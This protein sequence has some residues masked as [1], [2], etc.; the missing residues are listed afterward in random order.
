M[1]IAV[2]TAAQPAPRNR[3]LVLAPNLIQR[4]S[5]GPARAN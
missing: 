4:E 1:K 3:S 5:T 2:L